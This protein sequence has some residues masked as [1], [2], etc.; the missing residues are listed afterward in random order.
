M[1]VLYCLCVCLCAAVFQLFRGMI[2][3]FALLFVVYVIS[4]FLSGQAQTMAIIKKKAKKIASHTQTVLIHTAV[5]HNKG[6]IIFRFRGKNSDTMNIWI[7]SR[8]FHWSPYYQ[9]PKRWR[10]IFYGIALQT[11]RH[12]HSRALDCSF[13]SPLCP[14]LFSVRII[15]AVS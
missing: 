2:I 6:Y 3:I 13:P 10:M 12:I 1:R 5:P 8:I 14:F 15:R 11:N 7:N 9:I 4:W